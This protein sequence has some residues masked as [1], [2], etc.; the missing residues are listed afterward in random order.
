MGN[1]DAEQPPIPPARQSCIEILRA[2]G[3]WP[4]K[5]SVGTAIVI[6]ATCDQNFPGMRPTIRP[7]SSPSERAG[8]VTWSNV[9]LSDNDTA[10]NTVT[11]VAGRIAFQVIRF[12]MDH[13]RRTT[14][15]ENGIASFP[16]G[17]L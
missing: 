13:Q 9:H 11:G 10:S 4:F 3:L 12:G 7:V 1:A 8:Y 16:E 2:P 17:D 5:D 14:I 6:V 15:G